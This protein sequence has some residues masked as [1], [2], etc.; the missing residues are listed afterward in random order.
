MAAF[1]IGQRVRTKNP[2]NVSMRFLPMV[3]KT[4][5][6]T[7]PDPTRGAGNWVVDIDGHGSRWLPHS[8]LPCTWHE[9]HLEPLIPPHEAGSWE[10]VEKLLPNLRKIE[11]PA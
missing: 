6:I 1:F 4:G 11:E 8:D 2:G 3:G 5:T 10:E 7:A 9:D